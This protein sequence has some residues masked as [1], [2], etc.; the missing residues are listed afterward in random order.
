MLVQV[1]NA[2]GESRVVDN[3]SKKRDGCLMSNLFG[4]V[5]GLGALGL[6][7]LFFA[8]I[9]SSKEEFKKE[10]SNHVEMILLGLGFVVIAGVVIQVLG[11]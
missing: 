5:A 4:V 10:K 6:V 2:H 9:T 1:Q 7:W 11:G 3:S 8:R